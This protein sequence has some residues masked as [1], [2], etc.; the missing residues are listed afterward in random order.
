MKA[1]A[2]SSAL[3]I[4]SGHRHARRDEVLG[5]IDNGLASSDLVRN[6]T[7]EGCDRGLIDGINLSRVDVIQ[8]GI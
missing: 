2:R 8:T 5:E 6:R 7:G 1:A 3:A 4:V